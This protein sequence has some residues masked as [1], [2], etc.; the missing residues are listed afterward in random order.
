[1]VA[2]PGVYSV[3]CTEFEV[4][5]SAKFV[6]RAVFFLAMLTVFFGVNYRADD[7]SNIFVVFSFCT[8]YGQLF[9]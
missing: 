5:F 7:T 6:S 9:T 3:R 8:P 1:M 4:I 2:E